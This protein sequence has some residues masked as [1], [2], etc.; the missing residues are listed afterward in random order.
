MKRRARLG[1]LVALLFVATGVACGDE[2]KM[3]RPEARDDLVTLQVAGR[4]VA[5]EVALSPAEHGRGLMGRTE[6]AD[7]RGM[8][9]LYRT[10]QMRRFWM[11]DTLIPLDIV[12]LDSAGTV[13]NVEEA[14]AG[15]EKPG[16]VSRRPARMVIE[17]NRGWSRTHGLEPGD[18]VAVPPEV[19]ERA[20]IE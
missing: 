4:A 3:A 18:T 2:P 11:K 19:L 14:P 1:A 9:F 8:L 5:F 17:L 10:E 7:D 15:V 12:F 13:I 20:L 6:M 16:F